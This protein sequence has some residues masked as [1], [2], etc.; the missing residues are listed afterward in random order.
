LRIGRCSR[1]APWSSPAPCSCGG[2]ITS[3]TAGAGCV[4]GPPRSWRSHSHDEPLRFSGVA[5]R[6]AVAAAALPTTA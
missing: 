5:D 1:P 2:S 3:G 6:H 4:P